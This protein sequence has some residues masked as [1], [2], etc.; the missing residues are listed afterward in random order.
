MFLSGILARSRTRVKTNA[1]TSLLRGARWLPAALW[2]AG[3]FYLSHQSAP[4]GKTA[5]LIE[6]I[7]A[8]LG[9]Y[10][11][12]ALLLCWALISNTNRTF[13]PRWVPVGLAFALTV[14]F[15]VSDE[16]HQAFVPGRTSSEADVA[17][18]AAGAS[19][20]LALSLLADRFVPRTGP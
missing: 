1:V 4:L 19:I 12:L 16:L 6:S 14:L 10:A 18:D 17:V 8:H 2:M 13:T 15:G 20:G 7:V 3:I 5:S 9:L 11:G